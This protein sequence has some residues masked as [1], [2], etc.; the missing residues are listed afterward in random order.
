MNGF[1]K[2]F[3]QEICDAKIVFER[4]GWCLT[5]AVTLLSAAIAYFV[6]GRALQPLRQFTAQAEKINQKVWCVSALMRARFK[7]FGS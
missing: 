5:A 7:S 3:S 4:V 1:L 6:S 2:Q